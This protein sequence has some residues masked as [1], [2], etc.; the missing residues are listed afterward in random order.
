[1]FGVLR[2]ATCWRV[3]ESI[4]TTLALVLPMSMTAMKRG[5]DMD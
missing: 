5:R 3:V 2:V 1:V 4:S